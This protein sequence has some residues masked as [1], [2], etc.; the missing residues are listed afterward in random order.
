M[1][2]GT[3]LLRMH[4]AYTRIVS[5]N[6]TVSASI[7]KK[8]PSRELFCLCFIDSSLDFSPSASVASQYPRWRLRISLIVGH[9]YAMHEIAM[10]KN[11]DN[12]V[13]APAKAQ[14]I[15]CVFL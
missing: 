7:N 5:S 14:I 9:S 4:T 12:A 10:A 3:S 6:L 8:A 11:N 1:A 2:E 13:S 15:P